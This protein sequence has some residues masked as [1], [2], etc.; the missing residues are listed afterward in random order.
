MLSNPATNQVQ[1]FVEQKYSY[2]YY[3]YYNYSTS[4]TCF[5]P[6][7]HLQGFHSSPTARRSRSLYSFNYNK[8]NKHNSS[9][10][11][12]KQWT[13]YESPYAI[14]ICDPQIC[15]LCPRV[16]SVP[17]MQSRCTASENLTHPMSIFQLKYKHACVR[18]CG[19]RPVR[20]LQ[21]GI[22]F[23]DHLIQRAT[24]SPTP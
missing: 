4:P 20:D 2:Y 14:S 7:R 16:P 23:S 13:S 5:V 21:H 18:L 17:V 8:I 3:Y 15:V 24:S 6:I 12:L 10:I 19:K 9:Y 1:K 22:S 11:K